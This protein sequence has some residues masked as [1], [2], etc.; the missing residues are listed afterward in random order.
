MIGS[1]MTGFIDSHC[2]L[3]Y[4]GLGDRIDEV[5]NNASSA[6]VSEFVSIATDLEDA[7]R[8]FALAQDYKSIHVVCGIHPHNA[9]KTAEGWD[10]ELTKLAWRSDVY[11]IGEM[12]LDYH[13]DFSDRATQS[14]VFR[15]QLEIAAAAEKPVV[16]HCRE[17]HDD[18]LR[19]LHESPKPPRVV[20]HCFTGTI[21]E[22]RS[23]LDHGHWIS[24]TG[25]VTF[26]KSDELR[27]VAR[28]IPEDRIMIETDSPYLSPEPIRSKRP[29]EPAHM[30]HTAECIARVRGLSLDEFAGLT[31]ANT[32]RFFNLPSRGV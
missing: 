12:G 4:E 21:A 28:L 32:R 9:A 14:H 1:D 24:L 17:A 8:A 5:M 3:T 10:A 19:I 26:K 31:V 20:F 15:R 13:Y 6:G 2:H 18:T 27:E 29:N 11:G 30:I 16:I 22:A 7:K 23:I 25:V